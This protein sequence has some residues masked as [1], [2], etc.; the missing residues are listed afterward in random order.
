MHRAIGLVTLSLVAAIGSPAFALQV[1]S[2]GWGRHA[3][4]GSYVHRQTV[5]LSP[6]YNYNFETANLSGGSDTIMYLMG[7]AGTQQIEKNDDYASPN[8]ASK[9]SLTPFTGAAGEYDI[10]VV[11]YSNS[12]AGTC[13]LQFNGYP[14]VNGIK[15]GGNHVYL[16]S[17]PGYLSKIHA[18]GKYGGPTNARLLGFDGSGNLREINDHDTHGMPLMAQLN[19]GVAYTRVIVGTADATQEGPMWLVVNDAY[20][21]DDGDGIG[22]RAEQ[23]MCTCDRRTI[24]S[25]GKSCGSSEVTSLLDSD[26]DGLWDHWEVFGIQIRAGDSYTL[27]DQDLPRWGADPAHKDLFVELDWTSIVPG[28]GGFG[29]G[30][31]GSVA[32]MQESYG[33]ITA[34]SLS[35]RDGVGGLA[36]HLDIGAPHGGECTSALCGDWKGASQVL[37][38]PIGDGGVGT[39]YCAPND[40]EFT[41]TRRGVFIR[42]RP[43]GG[44]SCGTGSPFFTVANTASFGLAHEMGHALGI[45]HGGRDLVNS[46]PNYPSL[47]SYLFNY[48]E[49]GWSRG[50][51]PALSAANLC[52]S[53]GLQTTTC[54]EI[55]Y[56]KLRFGYYL[57]KIGGSAY[58]GVDWN[59]DGAVSPCGTPVEASLSYALTGD[60]ENRRYYWQWSDVPAFNKNDD[61]NF[62]YTSSPGLARAHGR[63]Y[64][65]NL[66]PQGHVMLTNTTKAHFYQCGSS[67][68]GCASWTARMDTGLVANVSTGA[69]VNG[70]GP[71]LV[72]DANDN[73]IVVFRS[74]VG[75][76]Y[77]TVDAAGTVSVVRTIPGSANAR[78]DDEPIVGLNA[79]GQPIVAWVERTSLGGG[80]WSGVGNV[81]IATYNHP[82]FG[83]P[84]T[85]NGVFGVPFDVGRVLA[86]TTGLDWNRDEEQLMLVSIPTGGTHRLTLMRLAGGQWIEENDLVTGLA[87]EPT[88]RAG[89]AFRPHNR[90]VNGADRGRY[91]AVYVLAPGAAPRVKM[92][93]GTVAERLDWVG[94]S[95]FDNLN[96]ASF[97]GVSLLG[98][99][100]MGKSEYGMRYIGVY[101]EEHAWGAYDRR[102][103]DFFPFADGIVPVTLEGD[104]DV[105]MIRRGVCNV[106]QVAAPAGMYPAGHCE[107]QLP[108]R[109]VTLNWP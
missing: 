19:P 65:A 97:C 108:A 25:C 70:A 85:Q 73:L 91:Y 88:R 35:N 57:E 74:A 107:A 104:D 1:E 36:V 102:W 75:L 96:R 21:D 24:S 55:A 95:S 45:E 56:L 44:Q 14:W 16:S 99:E 2:V 30:S 66:D 90:D 46:K 34:G 48:I 63:L 94:N 41:P 86:V 13:D 93:K 40:A 87:N 47:M 59:H 33:T 32:R 62:D 78:D 84:A 12:T 54:A 50:T 8:R 5:W 76:Q 29:P 77:A 67:D 51:R 23:Q 81:R 39:P 82:T 68:R 79:A 103:M 18:T 22:W 58:C 9:I 92:T 42:N 49:G 69:A 17:Q 27:V 38:G 53:N 26:G 109:A 11:A 6:G 43:G 72:V 61:E 7:A 31:P 106:L 64:I 3:T 80:A 20:D 37:V 105:E 10:I 4:Y 15:F 71:A 52:E 83:A 89:L 28:G 98:W 101:T 60:P 100:R